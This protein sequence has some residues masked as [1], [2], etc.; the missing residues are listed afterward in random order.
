M[1]YLYYL[2]LTLK[3]EYPTRWIGNVTGLLKICCPIWWFVKAGRYASPDCYANNLVIQSGRETSPD[4]ES[5]KIVTFHKVNNLATDS[6]LLRVW[7][8]V[9]WNQIFGIIWYKSYHQIVAFTKELYYLFSI[10][11]RNCVICQK[12]L[13]QVFK[14]NAIIYC[15]TSPDCEFSVLLL[16]KPFFLKLKIW[17]WTKQ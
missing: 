13:F 12:I 2:V 17:I 15:N 11:W 8:T 5:L 9:G 3:L 14:I 4:S 1:V 6:N 7:F 10:I 16:F